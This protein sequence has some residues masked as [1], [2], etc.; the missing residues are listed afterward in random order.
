MINKLIL[1]FVLSTVIS[2]QLPPTKVSER[3]ESSHPLFV[4]LDQPIVISKEVTVLD[5]RA[6]FDFSMY[7]L[8]GSQF[9]RWQD[10]LTGKSS[11]KLLPEKKISKKLSL[12]NVHPHKSHLIIGDGKTSDFGAMAWLLMSLGVSDVQ[13]INFSYFKQGLTT[14]ASK[15]VNSKSWTPNSID[16]EFKTS[17]SDKDI[18]FDVRPEPISFKLPLN[19]AEFR[20]NKVINVP[21]LDMY[22]EYGRPKKSIISKLKAINIK[23]GKSIVVVSYHL[24]EAAAASYALQVLGFTNVKI[25]IIK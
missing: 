23:S 9:V 19:E 13:T 2:C 24:N 1:L 25:H 18:I 5:S 20:N 8:E 4:K 7:H 16:K 14:K 12:K 17:I 21:W 22:N 6:F 10:Y 3:H 11:K 15:L